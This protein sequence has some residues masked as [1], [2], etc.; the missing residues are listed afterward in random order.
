MDSA[1]CHQDMV[2]KQRSFPACTE[3]PGKGKEGGT[4]G[5]NMWKQIFLFFDIKGIKIVFFLP[6]L[7]NK[8]QEGHMQDFCPGDELL[9]RFYIKCHFD[10]PRRIKLCPSVVVIHVAN[11]HCLQFTIT[12]SLG[13]L[14]CGV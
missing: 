2:I 6:P 13:E 1:F 7:L 12:V 9:I 4:K 10:L 8:F 3:V 14:I 11:C 5:R